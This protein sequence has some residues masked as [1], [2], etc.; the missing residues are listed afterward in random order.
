MST[1]KTLRLERF[2]NDV[3]IQDVA[4]EM[5]VSRATVYAIERRPVVKAEQ[6]A[7][8]RAAVAR[9]VARRDA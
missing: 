6:V 1:G 2:S 4:R 7:A 9:V 3:L 5:G 8:Y